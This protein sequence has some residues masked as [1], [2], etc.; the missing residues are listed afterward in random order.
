M[1]S[2]DV[3]STAS[4]QLATFV[5]GPKSFEGCRRQSRD[6]LLTAFALRQPQVLW[7]A[8]FSIAYTPVS[9]AVRCLVFILELK[10]GNKTGL[11]VF[12]AGMSAFLDIVAYDMG[13]SVVLVRSFRYNGLCAEKWAGWFPRILYHM[14]FVSPLLW[15]SSHI[16]T[17]RATGGFAW[18]C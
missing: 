11:S 14:C 8:G 13:L 1:R 10:D 4:I 17:F 5:I 2:P 16:T 7:L 15:N 3:C 9:D 6:A 18:T 12:K